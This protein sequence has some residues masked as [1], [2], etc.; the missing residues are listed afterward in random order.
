[1]ITVDYAS[2]TMFTLLA[3]GYIIVKVTKRG[4][5]ILKKGEVAA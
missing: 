3:T 1:M 2:A 5:A 4:K